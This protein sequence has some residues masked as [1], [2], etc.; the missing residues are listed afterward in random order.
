[1]RQLLSSLASVGDEYRKYSKTVLGV[2]GK[3]AS[4]LYVGSVKPGSIDI[5]LQ[6]EIIDLAKTGLAL[7]AAAGP[8]DAA[9]ALLDFSKHLDQLLD[10]FKKPPNPKDTTI[11]ECDNALNIAKNVVEAGSSQTINFVNVEGDFQPVY[12]LNTS[13]AAQI[14]K[15]AHETKSILEFPAAERLNS[16]AMVWKLLISHLHELMV[17]AAQTKA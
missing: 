12:T 9:K 3:D 10:K 2:S 17:S 8:V 5:F 11:S 7:T 13:Q 16:Q 14:A 4:K 1:M 15:N 6:P